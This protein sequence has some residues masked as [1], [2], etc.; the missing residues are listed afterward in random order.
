MV[1]A[2]EPMVDQQLLIVV[3]LLIEVLVLVSMVLVQ[4]QLLRLV[5]TMHQCQLVVHLQQVRW[6]LLLLL[7]LL[8]MMLLMVLLLMVE[9]DRPERKGQWI[10][11]L[12]FFFK[13]VLWFLCFGL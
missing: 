7:L 8:M 4:E 10:E 13:N 3:L 12:Y 1:A 11:F 5:A 6:L 2:I 9:E